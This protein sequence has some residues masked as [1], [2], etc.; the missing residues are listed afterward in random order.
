MHGESE[1]ERGIHLRL[2][3]RVLPQR[4]TPACT[5]NPAPARTAPAAPRAY[6]RMHGE[7]R[8][9]A[10]RWMYV[11]GLP[12]HARGIP[13]GQAGANAAARA[14][15]AG[16]GIHLLR[17]CPLVHHRP[18]PACTGNPWWWP[19]WTTRRTG[20]PRKRGE[21]FFWRSFFDAPHGLSPHARGIPRPPG[22]GAERPRATTAC[23]GNPPGRSAAHS[24][25]WAYSRMHGEFLDLHG[26]L[27]VDLGL[28]PQARG[29]RG[30]GAVGPRGARAT[31]AC[32]G[33]PPIIYSV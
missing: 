17:N 10:H 15:P 27:I 8:R 9:Y 14:T 21:S 23:T 22:W 26:E 18:T 33:N 20:Y 11:R 31:P 19:W 5:R 30:R 4:A 24:S 1:R 28:P 25:P 6:P 7:S 3:L 29:I 13:L 2:R 12:P 16:A 32:T